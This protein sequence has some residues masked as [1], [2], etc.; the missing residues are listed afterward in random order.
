[1]GPKERDCWDM[2]D[3]DSSEDNRQDEQQDDEEALD[4]D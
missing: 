1:M 4:F 3:Y 2:D